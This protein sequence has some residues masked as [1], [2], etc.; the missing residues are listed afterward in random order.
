MRW[1]NQPIAYVVDGKRVVG[2]DNELGKGDRR[3]PGKRET[4]YR[5]VSPRQLLA[6]F[7]DDVKGIGK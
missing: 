4:R 6:D 3:H 7:M 2:Y 5:F 1:L